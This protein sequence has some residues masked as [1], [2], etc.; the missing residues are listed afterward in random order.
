MPSVTLPLNF[1]NNFGD[2]IRKVFNVFEQIAQF[3]ID[4]EIVLNYD[5]PQFTHPFFT[6]SIPLIKKQLERKGYNIKIQCNISS[7]SIRSYLNY[8][9]F[10]GGVDLDIYNRSNFQEEL[11]IYRNKSYIPILNFPTSNL[12]DFIALREQYLSEINTLL[13]DIC[14]VQ[15]Q[16][17]TAL[18]YL[19][20]EAIN[21][22]L[23]HS[24]DDSGYIIAQYYPSKGYVDLAIAD[25]G[26]TLLESY[27]NCPRYKDT[28]NSEQDA[29]GAALGGKST[30]SGNVD[31]GFGI[32]TS[33]DMLIK[34]MGG[35]YFLWSGNVFNIHTSKLNDVVTISNHIFWQGVYVFL[36]IPVKTAEE[37]DPYKFME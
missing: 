33:K 19:I 35:K 9:N 6:L 26:R 23:N 14:K 15:A 36:R 7:P 34:G 16:A 8:L 27:K 10:P 29:M 31:R 1:S 25:I 30:K 12:S 2:P 11:A 32:S 28:I 18:M 3:N 22:I 37:F 20:D 13:S 21:N 17:R 5:N 24:F 4:D